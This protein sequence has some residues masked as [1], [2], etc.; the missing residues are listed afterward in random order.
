M[1]RQYD[2]LVRYAHFVEPRREEYSIRVKPYRV[3]VDKHSYHWA[4][5]DGE[6]HIC[7]YKSR[8]TECRTNHSGYIYF[9]TMGETIRMSPMIQRSETTT[10]F[11]RDIF[12]ALHAT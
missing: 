2:E 11:A 5:D 7:G 3:Y 10:R 6:T 9:A 4:A 8:I 1:S 12:Y